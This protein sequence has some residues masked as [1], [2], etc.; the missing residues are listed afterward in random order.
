MKRLPRNTGMTILE[1]AVV[2]VIIAIIASM[3]LPFLGSARS[4]A[5]E[6]RC[7]ANLRNLFVGA[8]G[9]MQA[10]G[11]WPQI[12]NALILSDQKEYARMWV[13]ALKPY[14]IPYVTWICPTIQG[15]LATPIATDDQDENY[16]VDYI[17]VSFDEEPSSP[18]PDIPYP[19]F[20]E[21]SGAHGRGNL[22]ILS[23]GSTKS[24]EDLK[25]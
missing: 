23:D 9:Y 3:L 13:A 15:A 24:I 6:A 18:Y 2:M 1:V 10:N 4:R 14:G 5:E 8:S 7:H 22:F 20:V 12:P 21:K 25:P 19:W 11:S 17:G 16:R